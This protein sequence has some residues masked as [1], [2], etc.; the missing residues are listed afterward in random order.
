MTS[1]AVLV[2]APKIILHEKE[3]PYNTVEWVKYQIKRW[4]GMF[5]VII[6][7]GPW[8]P[9]F[10]NCNSTAF[11]MSMKII[12]NE[13][14]YDLGSDFDIKLVI[15]PVASIDMLEATCRIMKRQLK[16]TPTRQDFENLKRLLQLEGRLT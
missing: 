16:M 15:P 5:S 14:R 2:V 13:V 4:G 12:G 7:S 3:P 9:D 8:T 11:I 1:L 6:S 10:Q